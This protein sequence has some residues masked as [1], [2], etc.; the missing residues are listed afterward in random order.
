MP[1]CRS[2]TR[3]YFLRDFPPHILS[4]SEII[5]WHNT[6]AIKWYFLLLNDVCYFHSTIIIKL[7]FWAKTTTITERD[8]PVTGAKYDNINKET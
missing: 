8:M 2:T 1:L 3:Q 6:S 7:G 4:V 5:N